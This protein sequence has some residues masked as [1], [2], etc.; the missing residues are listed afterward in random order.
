MLPAGQNEDIVSYTPTGRTS[1]HHFLRVES[2]NTYVIG[3]PHPTSGGS[4]NDHTISGSGGNILYQAGDTVII[5]PARLAD[6]N[7]GVEFNVVV[8]RS[9]GTFVQAN[10]FSFN[11]PLSLSSLDLS[12]LYF[13]TTNTDNTESMNVDSAV[14]LEHNGTGY[15]R[16][17]DL[18]D[19]DFTDDFLGKYRIGAGS[20][21]LT[22]TKNMKF[23]GKV[24]FADIQAVIYR[25]ENGD[26]ITLGTGSTGGGLTQAQVEQLLAEL[27]LTDLADTPNALGGA[28][29]VLVVKADGTETEWATISGG[30]NTATWAQVGDT[31]KIPD[32]KINR[33]SILT[34]RL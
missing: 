14:I 29:Q 30:G 28:G 5:S 10:T 9:N 18:Q 25:D 34:A 32:D 4:D 2:D 3:N 23:T 8:R 16:H 27:E 13:H 17:S 15:I 12:T 31:S 7:N 22:Q 1:P 26:A 11:D 6:S 19:F 24:E 33:A 21:T 20:D